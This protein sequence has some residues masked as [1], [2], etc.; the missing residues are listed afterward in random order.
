MNSVSE[1][2]LARHLVQTGVVT[3]EQIKQAR[4]AQAIA[5]DLNEKLSLAEALLQEGFISLEQSA[6]LEQSALEQLSLS[7]RRAV[8]QL[9]NYKLLK[10]LGEG[11]M[12]A[13]YLAEDL[14]VQRKVAVKVLPKKHAENPEFLQRFKREAQATG[15]LNHPNIVMAYSVGE[16]DGQ[17]FFAME[18]CEGKPL[19]SILKKER[20]LEPLEATR[21]VLQ[22]ARGLQHAHEHGFV[23]R[24]IKPGNI[25]LTKDGTAKILDLGLSKDTS[26][27]EQSFNTQTGAILGTPHYISP[28][29]A[30]GERSVDNRADIYSL[31]ATLYHLVTGEPPFH[32]TNVM[33][34]LN[35]HATQPA[36]DAR[37]LRP[38]IPAGVAQVIQKMLAKEPDERYASCDELAY[39]LELVRRGE[40]PKHV[41]FMTHVRTFAAPLKHQSAQRPLIPGARQREPKKSLLTFSVVVGGS[42]ILVLGAVLYFWGPGKNTVLKADAELPASPNPPLAPIIKSPDKLPDLDVKKPQVTPQ[43]AVQKPY[44]QKQEPSGPKYELRQDWTPIFDGT[45]LDFMDPEGM[46]AWKIKDGIL[47]GVASPGKLLQ[48]KSKYDL[49]DGEIRFRFEVPNTLAYFVFCVRANTDQQF[50]LELNRKDAY[51]LAGKAHDL[52]FTCVG[53]TVT[54]CLDGKSVEVKKQWSQRPSVQG[55]FKVCTMSHYDGVLKILWIDYRSVPTTEVSKNPPGQWRPLFDGT[56]LKFLH[57]DDRKYWKIENGVMVPVPG[58]FSRGT[59]KLQFHN[60]QLRIRFQ[61]SSRDSFDIRVRRSPEGVAFTQEH[62]QRSNAKINEINELIFT[63]VD[64]RSAA[65][66]NGKPVPIDFSGKGLYGPAR[67]FCRQSLKI[68]SVEFRELDPANPPDIKPYISEDHDT[69]YLSNMQEMQASVGF[70]KFGKEGDL[71]YENGRVRVKGKEVLHALSAHAPSAIHYN[72]NKAFTSFKTAVAM[73]DTAGTAHAPALFKVLGDEKM[74]WESKP[75]QKSGDSQEVDLDVSGVSILTLVIGTSDIGKAHT[76][77]VDPYLKKGPR[78]THLSPGKPV[79]WIEDA[80]PAGAIEL[81]GKPNVPFNW[82]NNN[83]K[84]FSGER[85]WECRDTTGESQSIF[86]KASNPLNV[87]VGDRFFVYAYL[88]PKAPPTEIMLKFRDDAAAHAEAWRHRAYWGEDKL[89]IGTA[90]TSERRCLGL[91]PKVGEWVLL[92]VPASSVGFEGRRL[93]GVCF[94]VVDGRVWFDHFGKLSDVQALTPSS[95]VNHKY[96]AA[97]AFGNTLDEAFAALKRRD[98]Q[99]FHE[100]LMNASKDHKLLSY[101]AAIEDEIAIAKYMEVV[102]L[103]AG[104]AVTLLA[105]KRAFTFKK[106][107]GKELQTGVGT[108]NIVVGI[109]DGLINISQ[110]LGSGASATIKWKLSEL[111]PACLFALAR[112]KLG[113]GSNAHLQ[114][115]GATLQLLRTGE[116]DV[117]IKEV[118]DGLELARQDATL[119]DPVARVERRLRFYESEM[120]ATNG[121]KDLLAAIGD[122][123]WEES[124]RLIKMLNEK[125]QDTIIVARQQEA[126]KKLG[127]KVDEQRRAEFENESRLIERADLKKRAGTMADRTQQAKLLLDAAVIALKLNDATNGVKELDEIAA[128]YGT[129]EWGN[130]GVRAC[131]EKGDYLASLGKWQEA[132]KAYEIAWTKYKGSWSTPGCD[133][134]LKVVKHYEDTGDLEKAISFR[135][136]VIDLGGVNNDRAAESCLWLADYYHAKQDDLKAMIYLRR[137]TERFK[138]CNQKYKTEANEKLKSWTKKP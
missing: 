1:E 118:A 98:A 102:L 3:A 52:T 138:T 93:T 67:F 72:L 96:D 48:I 85:A 101:K 37:L 120:G 76:V 75:L 64:D 137:I 107:D 12:G 20:L 84:P 89:N 122:N 126:L 133:A 46:G 97:I 21:I 69:H 25:I 113:T 103:A 112:I 136:I 56:T 121:M 74:L 19:D 129:L 131:V 34:I 134:A 36:P 5:L 109:K 31:G 80:L 50:A 111:S 59:T 82:T 81:Q 16:Q 119:N 62:F 29:Q 128:E 13:V 18:Y 99:K 38:E 104:D 116:L 87:E 2:M 57:E 8:N 24:D 27:V 79:V 77:W 125:F 15:K 115:S 90:N 30:K 33:S 114:F 23:H 95:I 106:T 70:G 51:A 123:K 45:S 94:A 68:H 58:E 105:D 54:A 60:G 53:D 26:D 43:V 88:D 110:D 28:E 11:G 83:P 78:S 117:P 73:N 49:A 42:A 65:T 130:I 4:H 127:K 14:A 47:Q 40:L 92:E 44:E 132:E 9:G 135:E 61:V 63:C 86:E 17:H 66:L 91:L 124:K 71:G 39:D 108:K 7:G 41:A 10:K 6:A 100:I 55:R 35:A 32:G 22:V